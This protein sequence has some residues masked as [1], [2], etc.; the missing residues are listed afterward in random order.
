MISKY[1]LFCILLLSRLSSEIAFPQTGGFSGTGFAALLAAEG[2]RLVLALPVIIYSAKGRDIYGA[3][4][5]KNRALGFVMTIVAGFSAAFLAVRTV[6]LTAEYA[7]RTIITGMSAAVI[8]VVIAAFAV[9]MAVKGAEALSRAGVLF[10]IAAGIVTLAVVLADIPHIRMRDISG[11]DLSES[12]WYHVLEQLLRGGEYL[13]FAAL[14]PYVKDGGCGTMLTFSLCSVAGVVLI[15][16]FSMSVLGEFYSIAEYPF[17][18]A[19]QLSDITLFK[20]LDGFAAAVWTLGGAFRTGLLLYS[21]YAA[22]SSV[23]KAEQP[24][25]ERR[26][27]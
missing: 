27:A 24:A 9:Y 26:S 8:A 10:L 20:R 23:I 17:T 5:R 22:I 15:G 4:A 21:V 1:Q 7:Q 13:I 19:A 11:A 25:A 18:A 16:V 12:F 2:I 3:A 6:L 14:L